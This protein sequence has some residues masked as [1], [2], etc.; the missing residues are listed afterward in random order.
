MPAT[1]TIKRGDTWSQAFAWKQGSEVGDPVDLTGATAYLHLRD[2]NDTLILDC[3][4][5][6]LVNGPAGTV[7]VA[8]PRE[9]TRLLPVGKFQFDIELSID[10]PSTETM[11][12]RVL[13][14]ET[15]LT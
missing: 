4:P 10:E 8:V 9:Q 2:R 3:S 15:V 7:S 5:Y 14:D 6:L 12:L 13:E 11:T 1:F